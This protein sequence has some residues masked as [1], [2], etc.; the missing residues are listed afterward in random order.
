M[1]RVLVASLGLVVAVAGCG[2]DNNGG[3]DDLTMAGKVDQS[4]PKG[5]GGGGG[6]AASK[7]GALPDLGP[8]ADLAY[9]GD[10]EAP[11][12]NNAQSCGTPGNCADCTNATNGHMC[13]A[14][15]C[16]CNSSADCPS[17]SACDPAKHTCGT[18]C[19]NG[20]DCNGG[21]CDGA[22]CVVGTDNLKCGADG[23]ACVPCGA[24]TP[25]CSKGACSATC[26]VGNGGA[27]CGNGFCCDANN[28]CQ[29][30][31]NNS[32]G[33]SG[34][35]CVDCSKSANGP[36]CSNNGTC[37]CGSD[38][39]C[40][41]NQA[42]KGGVCGTACDVNDPCNGGCC[43]PNGNV[44]AAG[45]T[46]MACATTNSKSCVSCANNNMGTACVSANNMVF[47]GCNSSTDCPAL[48]A[49]NTTTHLCGAACDMNTPCNGGCCTAANN[50]TCMQGTMTGACGNSGGLCSDC[51]MNRNGS[52]CEPV[53]GG[54]QCGC[55]MLA[56][57]TGMSAGATS[58]TN[59]ICNFACDVNNKCP[60]GCCS[61]M[62]NG[63]CQTGT[64]PMACGAAMGLC[65]DC[66]NSA[67]GHACRPP[68]VCG[69]N[70]PT[71]CP[72][73]Q[74]C[75]NTTH[76]CS[77]MCGGGFSACNGGCCAGNMCAGG[78]MPA[79]CGTMNNCTDCTMSNMGHQCVAGA[80][81]CNTA[82]DCPALQACD[83]GRHVCTNMCNGNQACNG[84]CCSNGMCVAGTQNNACGT[85][86]AACTPCAN[87]TPTC[88]AGACTS[89][90]GNGG[91]GTCG[92]GFCCSANK[93]VDG[94][95]QATC[96]YSGVCVG[97]A[98][99][100]M[101]TKC[102]TFN[103]NG[104]WACGCDAATDCL[105][106]NPMTNSAGQSCDTQGH[107][108]TNK[109]R[110][111]GL[112][113]CNGGCCTGD[114]GTC[115]GGGADAACGITGGLCNSC[116]SCVPG[117][118]CNTMTGACGCDTNN[119]CNVSAMCTGNGKHEYECNLSSA[120]C[121]IPGVDGFTDNGNPANCCVG[122]STNGVCDCI[123][124]GKSDNGNGANCCTLLID[125]NN[126]CAC[127][128]RNGMTECFGKSSNCC[129]G[130]NCANIGNGRTACF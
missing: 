4:M 53:N 41:M 95:K 49:C 66:T 74:S 109:C 78:N 26:A 90:C 42:C 102:E 91:N 52:K 37:G 108:C 47:C 12:A 59:G 62:M 112:T 39:D 76:V 92:G 63:T 14:N 87:G 68:G 34:A 81:G 80:C 128:P 1:K 99:N 122:T 58:C 20:L 106:A 130:G 56:D 94:S 36:I 82:A 45:N 113:L 67:M 2:N 50:G 31:G 35:A 22:N 10:G 7:D 9:T 124:I 115:V 33:P 129:N 46:Q 116:E 51:S 117:P 27:N 5:D 24:G 123:G 121:C 23:K 111:N 60:N 70:G 97:C 61:A 29:T 114:N 79:A 6:D 98:N 118:H 119:E 88:T 72:M 103:A 15:V 3:I 65:A 13:V 38:T 89:T 17:G 126:N 19:A 104:P 125:N 86:G 85:N 69:C 73:G 55:M 77:A 105:A 93:C 48:T 8:I 54:G 83:T 57:C 120:S 32:C 25:T 127:V 21:C 107:N 71:D 28:T 110:V 84:G 100:S 101:G 18:G 16:G 11:C 40:P 96:G 44:C 64:G 30:V 43:N 75:N